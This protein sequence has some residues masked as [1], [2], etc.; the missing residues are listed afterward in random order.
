MLISWLVK[1]F[2]NE[3]VVDHDPM[4]NRS[5]N[6]TVSLGK[7]L[8]IVGELENSIPARNGPVW[9]LPS[10]DRSA[11]QCSIDFFCLVI[12][13][14]I[15]P[16]RMPCF[17]PMSFRALLKPEVMLVLAMDVPPTRNNWFLERVSA[18]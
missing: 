4:Q 15:A 17:S 1:T 18:T 10:S 13:N 8:Q 14:Y 12:H 9:F 2:S 5:L 7:V 6:L 11:E 16:E 3:I